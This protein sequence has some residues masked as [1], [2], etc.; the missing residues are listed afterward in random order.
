MMRKGWKKRMMKENDVFL[1]KD[2]YEA[3]FLYANRLKLLD[4]QKEDRFYWFVFE[5]KELAEELSK[6]YWQRE[7]PIDAST[8][9]E[10]IRSLKDRLYARK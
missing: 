8:Y 4:L 5:N 6:K 7:A 9:A 10:A 3:S 1:T 2:L